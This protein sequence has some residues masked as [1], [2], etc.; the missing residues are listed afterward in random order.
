MATNA[1]TGETVTVR[2]RWNAPE[3][4]DV[5]V[6]ALWDF[7]V[8]DDAGGVCRATPRAFLYAHVW[9]DSMAAGSLGHDCREGPAPHDLLVMI[10]PNDN[11]SGLYTRLRGK[12]R[13]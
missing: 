6:A 10:L 1:P 11:P 2:R 12:T 3:T 7:H 13:R 8:R 4:A 5:T 9:C